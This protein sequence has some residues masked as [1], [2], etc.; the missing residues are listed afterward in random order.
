MLPVE[1]VGEIFAYIEFLKVPDSST[2]LLSLLPSFL[3]LQTKNQPIQDYFHHLQANLTAQLARYETE[4]AS[5]SAMFVVMPKDI[6]DDLMQVERYLTEASIHMEY[7]NVAQAA[8]LATGVNNH[9]A[10]WRQALNFYN[11][12]VTGHQVRSGQGSWQ[13]R[14]D[15]QAP[16]AVA[17]YWR[18][19]QNNPALAQQQQIAAA[20]GQQQN[21]AALL[22]APPVAGI[23]GIPYITSHFI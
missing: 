9:L 11:D 20:V 2:T 21:Q 23:L 13:F 7:N 1:L 17:G 15:E 14:A 19:E 12:P 22:Q 16:M 3:L 5:I 10:Q 18:W 6:V 8:A 4:L